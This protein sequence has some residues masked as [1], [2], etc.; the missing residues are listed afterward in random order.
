M[1]LAPSPLYPGRDQS[2][3]GYNLS[4]MEDQQ[5]AGLIMW[6]VAGLVYLGAI[7]WLFVKWFSEAERRVRAPGFDQIMPLAVVA[8]PA[9]IPG[10]CEKAS[11]AQAKW[12]WRSHAWLRPDS[13]GGLRR[14]SCH[15][16]DRFCPGSRRPFLVDG[17][18]PRFHRRPLTQFPRDHGPLATASPIGSTR[19]C[20]AS[21]EHYRE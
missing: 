19:K 20:D 13:A 15:P 8:A 2:T 21:H 3:A 6:V 9:L 16:R 18:A 5:L 12:R 14:L 1:I 11:R 10:G 4:P 7:A 17:G